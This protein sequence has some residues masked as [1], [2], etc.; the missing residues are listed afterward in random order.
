[1][2]QRGEWA[3]D[4]I[5]EIYTTPPGYNDVVDHQANFFESVRTRKPVVENEV[6]GS[7]TSI[8]CHMSNYSYFN[9]T[10]AVWDAAAKKI[11]G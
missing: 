2:P 7:N 10:V 1:L 5:E 8:G 6:F 3:T 11:K 9:K 4:D